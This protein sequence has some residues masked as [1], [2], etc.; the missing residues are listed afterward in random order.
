MQGRKVLVVGMARSGVAAARMLHE[1]GALVRIADQKNEAELGGQ[2]DEL[3][4]DGIE[5]RLGEPAETLL[6]G[7]DLVVVSPGVPVTHPA[8][9]AARRIGLPVIG[10]LE[11]AYRP[12]PGQADRHHRH[13]RKDH[14]LHADRRNLQKRWEAYVRGGQHWRALRLRGAQD[15]PG[16]RDRCARSRPSSWRRS[17]NSI[18]RSPP[19]STSP[20]IT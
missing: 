16:G 4:L 19:S 12:R 10:E 6:E 15:P 20:R 9:E 7:M 17:K 8:I 5:W 13:Q 2:L 1:M 3:R 11:L 18:R 14:H